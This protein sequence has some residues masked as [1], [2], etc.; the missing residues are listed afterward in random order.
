MPA[1]TPRIV[2]TLDDPQLRATVHGSLAAVGWPLVDADEARPDDLVHVIDAAALAAHQHRGAPLLALSPDEDTVAQAFALGADDVLRVPFD[3]GELGARV[4]R[5]RR[6]R[7]RDL[8]LQ[9][10]ARD[11]RVLLELT[12]ALTLTTDAREILRMVVRRLGDVAAVERCSVVLARDD[13]QHGYVVASN[14]VPGEIDRPIELGRYPEIQEVLTSRR[15]LLIDDA[16]THPLLDAVRELVSGTRFPFLALFPIA[17]EHRAFGVLFLRASEERG[18]LDEREQALCETVANATAAALRNAREIQQLREER[19]AVSHARLAAERRLEVLEPYADLFL[20]SADGM[21][22]VD[23]EGRPLY[24]NPRVTE[25]SGYSAAEVR[26]LK[27]GDVVVPEDRPRLRALRDAFGRQEYPSKFDLR[28]RRRDGEV[29]TLSLSTSAAMRDENAVLVTVRDV[30]AERSTAAELARTQRFLTSLIESSP[31][32]IVAAANSGAVLLLNSAAERILGWR[33]ADLAADAVI[34]GFFREGHFQEYARRVHGTAE[35]RIE[36]ARSE[37]IARDGEV[38]PVLLSAATLHAEGPGA[39]I[40]VIFSDQRERLRIEER[41]ARVQ[42]ELGRTEQQSMIAELSGAAAHELNQPLTAI[43]GH[44]ELIK[45]R[46]GEDAAMTRSAEVILREAGRMADIVRRLGQVSRFE[47][48]HYVGSAKILDL[49][50]SAPE[51]GR[52]PSTE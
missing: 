29:R 43:Q 36:G 50:R 37:V 1:V 40:V 32:A 41:L 17:L 9:R 52:P 26:A 34:D 44:A 45:R 24:S 31:D 11:A 33:R 39:G 38:I 20:S 15:P 18:R 46:A 8:D 27:M 22:V 7:E 10:H 28:V 42:S 2:I 12:Q 6:R 16:P 25:I 35:G 3:A 21:V 19:L 48:K 4:A 49:E 13:Y 23:L 51:S 5:L 30:T 47:T 14:D